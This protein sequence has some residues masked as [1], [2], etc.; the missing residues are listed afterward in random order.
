ML[1]RKARGNSPKCWLRC[2]CNPQVYIEPRAC[3][4]RP[5]SPRPRDCV[6]GAGW[7]HV[8]WRNFRARSSEW[9]ACSSEWRAVWYDRACSH[10]K[11]RRNGSL[12]CSTA[13]R[14]KGR[15]YVHELSSSQRTSS[16]TATREASA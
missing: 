11:A 13:T 10:E 12:A 16:S 6:C 1:T 14:C 9:R 8:C 2:P 7:S 3:A 15:S 5:P 4:I